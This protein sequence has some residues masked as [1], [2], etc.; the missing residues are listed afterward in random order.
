MQRSKQTAL[1]FLLGATLVGGALGFTAARYLSHEN[2][3]SQFAP[4]P[5]FYDELGLS[6]Q[7]RTTVDSLMFQQDC[8]VRSIIAPLRSKLDSVRAVFHSQIEHVFTKEQLTQL[9]SR[10]KEHDTRRQAEQAK[11]PKR[12]C[13]I[14]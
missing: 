4:R 7:Q 2:V 14:N 1:M 5:K 6:Q 9:D 10:R 3:L 12:A 13:S 8:A 11:E